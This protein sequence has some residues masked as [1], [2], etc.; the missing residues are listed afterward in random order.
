MDPTRADHPQ[1]VALGSSAQK[2]TTA[3]LSTVGDAYVNSTYHI[4]IRYAGPAAHD[5]CSVD[6]NRS[7][8]RYAH[9]VPAMEH[10]ARFPSQVGG[11]GGRASFSAFAGGG[12]IPTGP[13]AVRR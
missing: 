12:V 8:F 4:T 10:A 6:I 11:F 13:A 2:A 7:R 9:Y 1:D 3:I 5:G